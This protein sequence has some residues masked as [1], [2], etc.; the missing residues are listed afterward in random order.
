MINICI[1]ILLW[2]VIL[3]KEKLCLLEKSQN[4]S[5][6]LLRAKGNLLDGPNV[7]L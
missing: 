2:S 4:K 3:D 5:S 7:M 1:T 6:F